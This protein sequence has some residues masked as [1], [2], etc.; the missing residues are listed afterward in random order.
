MC[1]VS[2]QEYPSSPYWTRKMDT[3]RS[4][5]DKPSSKLCTFNTPWGRFRFPTLPFSIKSASEVLQQNN[6]E[7]FGDIQ[8]VHIITDDT[9]IAASSEKE[10]AEILHNV[11]ERA[12]AANVK[13]NR[14]EEDPV[15][16]Q[17]S[18]IHGAYHHARGTETR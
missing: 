9:I 13:F 2:W 4:K 18:E 11:L 7:P 14:D 16:G 1:A 6:C 8:G 15:Q 5:L 12:K 17:Q 3:G 10:H